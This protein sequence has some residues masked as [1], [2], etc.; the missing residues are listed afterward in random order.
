VASNII[1]ISHLSKYY[2]HSRGIEDVSLDVGQGEFFGFIGPNGAGKS[3]TIRILLNLIFPSSGSARIFGLDVLRDSKKIRGRLGYV[4]S[5]AN[6][7][8]KMKVHEFLSFGAAF[9]GGN[10][11]E[12]RIRELAGILDLNLERRITE[13]STGNKKKVNIIQ[14][15]VHKPELLILDE[16]TSG[17]DPLIQSK[18]FGLL[19]EEN[20]RGTTVFFSSHILSDV[21]ALCRRVAIVKEGRIVKSDE[22]AVLREKQLKKVRILFADEGTSGNFH[23]PG[24]ASILSV[25]PKTLE[26]MF[27]GDINELTGHLS[28]LRL[29]NLSIEEPP[30]EEIFLH[31]YQ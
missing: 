18:L 26:F 19:T 10:K 23:I 28:G 25:S 3:T 24:M 30:L 12:D 29:E 7:Y 1:E 8:D 14:A 17:L 4:P 15:L 6:L 20:K 27:S 9:Y 22:I 31:Y 5:D 16:P 21:Q 11:S 13:L 2:G